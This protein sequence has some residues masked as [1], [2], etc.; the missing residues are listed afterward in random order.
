MRVLIIAD[1]L[2]GAL[3]SA[4]ALTGA[5]L[6]CVAARRPS[7]VARALAERPEVL[8]VS[9]ASREGSAR[10]ARDAVGAALDA[11]GALPEI[12]FKKVDSRLKGHVADEVAILA[13]RTGCG[14]ALVAPAVPVQ[15]RTVAGGWLRGTGI[16]APVEVAGIFE[17]SGLDLV[18]PDTLGDADL[19]AAVGRALAGPP[20]LLVG[21]AGLAAALGRRIAAGDWAVP[22]PRLTA[23]VLFAIGSRDPITLEQVER[24]AASGRATVAE[25][26][27]GAVPPRGAGLVR[28]VAE[29][30][31]AFDPVRDGARFSDGIA[32]LVAS[33]EVGTLL[34]C[35]GETADAILGALGVGA[36]V[37]EGEVLPGLPVSSMLAGERPMRLVTKSGGFGDGD[38]LVFV[39]DAA[40]SPEECMR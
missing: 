38:A 19:D 2:T 28:L 29:G 21:A 34:A 14:R 18:V 33:G 3:D 36:L 17:E 13:E 24:L 23:P 11:V 25:A 10:E 1:D 20:T 12:V 7:D 8:A 27:G 40:A 22:V 35:G 16:A 4:V 26:P 6:R 9:T 5:G 30:G 37:V 39:L 15:G 32:G 31:R